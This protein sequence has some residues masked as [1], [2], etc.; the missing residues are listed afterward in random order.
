MINLSTA[1]EYTNKI[2]ERLYLEYSCY[3]KELKIIKSQLGESSAEVLETYS[4]IEQYRF[5][6]I[7]LLEKVVRTHLNGCS[8]SFKNSAEQKLRIIQEEAHQNNNKVRNIINIEMGKIKTELSSLR[9]P[10]RAKNYK[11]ESAPVLIDI[12]T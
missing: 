11:Q 2:L 7:S 5:R 4:G 6:Q 3:N 12:T 9:L 8:I 1:E 10:V